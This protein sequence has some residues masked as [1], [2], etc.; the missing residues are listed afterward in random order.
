[1]VRPFPI[2]DSPPFVSPRRRW[3]LLCR[4]VA[5]GIE[6]IKPAFVFR[7]ALST[8]QQRLSEAT[9]SS[10]RVDAGMPPRG[11]GAPGRARRDEDYGGRAGAG[12]IWGVLNSSGD[13]ILNPLRLL[14]CAA[15]EAWT[16]ERARGSTQ[17]GGR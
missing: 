8:L 10:R 15:H 12:K 9:A 1:M 3:N 4:I 2:G 17:R 6:A 13:I 11:R 7:Y 16:P 14:P 5:A